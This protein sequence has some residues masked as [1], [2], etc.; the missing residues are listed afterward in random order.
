MLESAR[1]WS[2]WSVKSATTA[3][4]IYQRAVVL[5]IVVACV[6]RSLSLHVWEVLVT[7]VTDCLLLYSGSDTYILCCTSHTRENSL[8]SSICR[9][10]L[11]QTASLACWGIKWRIFV[12]ATFVRKCIHSPSSSLSI[13]DAI[14]KSFRHQQYLHSMLT[15]W[16]LERTSSTYVT[17]ASVIWRYM[18]SAWQLT[19]WFYQVC[20]QSF[21]WHIGLY[22]AWNDGW[23]VQIFV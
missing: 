18:Q 23:V 8:R 9:V 17:G 6:Q 21:H 10:S 16:R 22:W 3:E 2:V 20:Q 15:G 14:D 11:F 13:V 5:D 7:R 4:Q 12:A 19:E 1:D